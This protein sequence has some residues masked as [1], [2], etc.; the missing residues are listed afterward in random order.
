MNLEWLINSACTFNF[1][2]LNTNTVKHWIN[3]VWCSPDVLWK[4]FCYRQVLPRRETMIGSSH[5]WIEIQDRHWQRQHVS[6][7]KDQNFIWPR[8]ARLNINITTFITMLTLCSSRLFSI[9]AKTSF[10]DDVVTNGFIEC[11]GHLELTQYHV[12]STVKVTMFI[13]SYLDSSSRFAGNQMGSAMYIWL[14]LVIFRGGG[15][16]KLGR[17]ELRGTREGVSPHPPPPPRQIEHCW[18]QCSATVLS[19]IWQNDHRQN[20]P[21]HQENTLNVLWLWISR[22][23]I[24]QH[25]Y[26]PEKEFH[27]IEFQG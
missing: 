10:W 16:Y 17:R 13:I 5:T 8:I 19:Q 14:I 1:V 21:R 11:M 20:S 18:I 26:R 9:S 4:I 7:H 3:I 25:K 2:H 6:L 15:Q 24:I 23:T 27:G 22:S 12:S